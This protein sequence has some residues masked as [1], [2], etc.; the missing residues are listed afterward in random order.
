M[1]K[2]AAEAPAP[3]AKSG[4]WNRNEKQTDVR[5]QNI[6]AA[7]AVADMIRTSMG[8]RGMDKMIQ[9]GKAGVVVTNDGATIL[10][11][12][13]LAH[14]TAKMMV[15]LSKS[16]DVEAGD[17]TTTVIVVCG[18]LLEM[19]DN[20][21][22]Q[23][24]H[25]QTVA[26][27]F[28]MAVEKCEELMEEIAQPIS[29][30]DKETLTNI[31][32]I[33]LHSKVV[34]TNAS[35]LAPIAVD[36]VLAVMDEKDSTNVDLNNIRVVKSIG[37]TVEDTEMVNGLV[38]TQ[39][40][41]IR[42]ASGPTR[43]VN[44]K[45]GLIQFCLSP[46]KTDMENT[47]VVKDYQSIDRIMREERLITARMVKQIAATGCNVL[48][49]QK[50]ILRDAVTDLSLDYL[51]KAKIMVIKDIEREDIEFIT[52][53]IGCEE[54]ASLDHFTKEKLGTA[55]LVES[56]FEGGQQIVKITGVN[57]KK[58]ASVLVRASNSLMLD[59]AE[60]SLHDALCVVRCLVKKRAIVAGG[61]ATE[62]A[63]S[64]RLGAWAR[65]LHG[66][67]QVCIKAFAE[68]LEVVP[69]TLAENAGL[70]PLK[71]ITELRN[72]HLEEGGTKFGINSK[73][74]AVSNMMDDK[75]IQPM[76][77]TLSALKLATET[78]MMILK[79]DD[80]VLCR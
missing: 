67:E 30:D 10:K 38:L 33:S 17:G 6:I 58:T 69:Y 40:K 65:T 2:V 31:A 28:K 54:V 24:I 59:E 64:Q 1:S 34:S 39:Q 46:P 71:V 11:E 42:V 56:E 77:V 4:V 36:S 61:G 22:N 60:R 15:E 73:K 23:G 8:P 18:A 70:H 32:A 52:R 20:L 3:A 16:Q 25:P 27:S 47:I 72:R 50:S 45:V 76:L 13:R 75:V 63:L 53:A 49:I 80:I 79:I 44:A 62:M 55:E 48:L 57:M 37:G 7:R 68:A 43:V 66:V 9:D 41:I 19:A 35:L 78:V 21:L 74:G 14:P 29:L 51:A 5:K 26:N 12:L